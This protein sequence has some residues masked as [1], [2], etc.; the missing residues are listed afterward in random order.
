MGGVLAVGVSGWFELE[1]GVLDADVEV[2]GHAV[3]EVGQHLGGVTV[4]EARLVQDD[5]SRQHG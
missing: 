4:G 1:S 2:F 3:L 5:V